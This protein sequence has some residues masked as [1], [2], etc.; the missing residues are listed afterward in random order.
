[1]SRQY[2]LLCLSVLLF[3]FG[4]GMAQ[5]N[6]TGGAKK[7]FLRLCTAQAGNN[8]HLAGQRIAET[9]TQTIEVKVI[10][11]KGSW[12]NLETMSA[13]RPRC[14]AI[15]AQDDAVALHQFQNKES[16]LAMERMTSLF[17]EKAHLLCNRKV[18]AKNLSN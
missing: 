3:T 7:P 8:Y 5:P 17:E 16:K 12:E 6:A 13:S 11:T 1:M 2:S 15:I 4:S 18:T 14:D 9:L 10:E